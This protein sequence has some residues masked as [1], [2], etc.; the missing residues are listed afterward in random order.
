MKHKY[1]NSF[2]ISFLMNIILDL[3]CFDYDFER[4]NNV[5]KIEYVFV[6]T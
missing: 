6:K 4:E 3:Y 2:F 5:K 1:I